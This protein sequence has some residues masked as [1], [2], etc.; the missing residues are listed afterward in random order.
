MDRLNRIQNI[1]VNTIDKNIC[2]SAG[3]G[4][5]KTKVLTERFLNIL[6]NGNL[7]KGYELE[8]ILAITYTNKAAF[9]MKSKIKD[10]LSKSKD[11]KL[12]D[13]Y[14]FFS[15]AQIFTIHAF[16]GELIRKYPL[17]V[18]VDPEF[19][20][21]EPLEAEDILRDATNT[22]FKK[23][24]NDMRLYELLMEISEIDI[25]KFS[26][27]I[28]S[29][30]DDL[31]NKSYSI[32]EIEIKNSEF[33]NE[34]SK[35]KTDFSTLIYWIHELGNHKKLASNSKFRKL[36]AGDDIKK[37]FGSPNFDFFEKIRSC[38]KDSKNK[39]IYEIMGKIRLEML[40]LELV[41][42][43]K[44]QKYYELIT[45]IL[46]DIEIEYTFKKRE[47]NYLDYEDLQKYALKILNSEIDIEYK[48]IMVDEFQDTNKIQTEILK[49]LT[50]NLSDNVN[51]FVVGDAKQS[52]YGFRGGDLAQYKKFVKEMESKDCISLDMNENYR[53]SSSLIESF[54][55]LFPKILGKEYT[56]LN[57]NLKGDEKIKILEFCDDSKESVVAAN[58]IDSLIKAGIDKKDIA[59]LFRT[60][61]NMESF[62]S[63]LISRNISVNNTAKKFSEFREIRDIIVL[64][65]ALS[66]NRD[67]LNILAYF[68]SPLVGLSENSIFKLALR[69][70]DTDILNF[71]LEKEL[72]DRDKE[73]F[74]NGLSKYFTLREYKN[75]LT[76]SEF[77]AMVVKELRC[78]EI[79][80]M[81]FGKNSIL[82]IDKLILLSNEFEKKSLNLEE[83]I[84]YV[85]NVVLDG[86]KTEDAV[87]LMTIHKSKGLEFDHIILSDFKKNLLKKPTE[88]IIKIGE[89]GLGIKIKNRESKYYFIIE[90]EKL[91]ELEEERRIFYVA[92][93]RAKK[94]LTFL[95]CKYKE[96]ED[97]EKGNENNVKNSY[98]ELLKNTQFN[99]LKI[100]SPSY[101]EVLRNSKPNIFEKLNMTGDC[102][103]NTLIRNEYF[104]RNKQFRYYSASGYMAFKKDPVSFYR[105]YILGD[106]IEY[107]SDG[108]EYEGIDPIKRGIIVHK[109]AQF[110]PSDIDEFLKRELEQNDIAVTN[111]VLDLLKD[112]IKNVDK[113]QRGTILHREYEFYYPVKN[114]IINGFIDQIREV[115]GDIEIIDF[116]TGHLTKESIEYYKLQLQIYTRAYE[117]ISGKHVKSAILI[118]LADNTEHEIDISK[119]SVDNTIADFEKFI[120]FVETHDKIENYY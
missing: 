62:E 29:L 75:V 87:T 59:I 82:N 57:A 22:V 85:Q 73:L 32:D 31:K 48:Y 9:E 25:R 84:N 8:E 17:A 102:E 12:K 64:L 116:K 119:T 114:G 3:A 43:P 38:V 14:K 18:E 66:N 13:I 41:N 30:Y 71:E 65:K 81:C 24:E 49:K 113:S 15:N 51:L 99:N 100:I 108:S 40:R 45:D 10:A 109:Y 7:T 67:I 19:E 94:T 28:I 6:K 35:I 79:F 77:I 105:T 2:L 56:N 93:T 86:E 23:Y 96:K 120:D 74:K 21:C 95:N 16:C 50:N 47:K 69:S 11:D 55:E 107:K 78:Y 52:I 106:E 58:Y 80:R 76:L 118:S 117:S 54:N 60:A 104:D 98:H 91:N 39:E 53:S 36:Y 112:R 37:F 92:A 5:G 72:D 97:I 101:E 26:D 61:K 111:D 83:F 20:I 27:A 1:A 33:L 89:N 90:A 68:K 115:N 42:E 44:N 88:N 46:K 70:K 34:I 4:T 103:N 110:C 63:E